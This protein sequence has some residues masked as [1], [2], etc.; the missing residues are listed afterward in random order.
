ML[1]VYDIFNRI[2]TGGTQLER[3][4]IRNCIFIGKS[5]K[6][7]KKLAESMEFKR[8]IDFGISSSRMKDREAVLRCL[9]FEIFDYSK[10]FNNSMDDFLER[11]MKKINRM[12]DDEINDLEE[13]FF[14]VM[15]WTLD[16][17]GNKNFRLPT[18]HSRGRINIAIME[19]VSYFF[20]HSPD[21]L[22]DDRMS[23]ITHNYFQILLNDPKY[24][25]SVRFSTGA[26]SKVKE[27]FTLA[28]QILT[29]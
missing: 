23:E 1:V 2:N 21:S 12:S 18:D 22:L 17:F 20:W 14:R 28:Q 29:T 8:A 7:L 3:Q 19:S 15:S 13:G 4:E 11:A 26:T 9:A 5:T 27:R 16:F 25:E 10:D 24:I 6:L